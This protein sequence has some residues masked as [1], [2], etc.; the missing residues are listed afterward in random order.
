LGSRLVFVYDTLDRLTEIIQQ[1]YYQNIW[2]NVWKITKGY[3][4]QGRWTDMTNYD[5]ENGAWEPQYWDRAHYN[6]QGQVDTITMYEYSGSTWVLSLRDIMEYDSLGNWRVF[7][8]EDHYGGNVDTYRYRF[9]YD[10]AWP[11]HQMLLPEFL[12]DDYFI[13]DRQLFNHKLDTMYFDYN[14]FGTWQSEEQLVFYY[15]QRNLSVKPQ[16]A[17][18]LVLFPNPAAERFFIRP[19]AGIRITEVSLWDMHGRPVRTWKGEQPSYKVSGLSPG[20]YH[21]RISTIKGIAVR[22]LLIK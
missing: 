2:E 3:D 16:S 21:V 19:Q 15:S 14:D 20:L 8:S 7:Y 9:A 17:L 18:S 13:G 11:Y 22:K 1:D 4:A 6:A 12:G 5:W 10:N